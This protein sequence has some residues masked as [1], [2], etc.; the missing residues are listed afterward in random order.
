MK[1]FCNASTVFLFLLLSS[2]AFASVE[3]KNLTGR[4]G[5]G[6][7]NQIAVSSDGTIPALDAKYYL[8]KFFATSIGLGFDSRSADSRMGLGARP[9]ATS[10]PA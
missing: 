4:L 5:L 2:T 10:P 3:E 1:K 8:S 6:F 9:D 7:T